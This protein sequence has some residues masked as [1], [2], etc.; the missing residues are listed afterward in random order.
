MGTR[1]KNTRQNTNV[2]THHRNRRNLRPSI[3][4]M[5]YQNI[6]STIA[7][8]AAIVAL[9]LVYTRPNPTPSRDTATA[10]Y[11]YDTSTIVHRHTREQI[12][13]TIVDTIHVNIPANIDTAAILKQYFTLTHHA[14][15]IR[16]TNIVA[17]IS[18]TIGYNRLLARTFKYQITRPTLIQKKRALL[19]IG[20]IFDLKGRVEPTLSISPSPKWM[21]HA[22][23]SL[24][25][26]TPKVG[27]SYVLVSQ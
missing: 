5:T 7:A 1:N 4:V 22:G 23:Y 27:F 2:S 12:E 11:Y 14:D 6:T 9:Y 3:S 17:V 15:T 25:E 8:I 20:G 19:L 10:T 21:L 16:D 13:R 26:K 18:D 24:T